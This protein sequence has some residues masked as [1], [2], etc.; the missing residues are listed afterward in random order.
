MKY[1]AEEEWKKFSWKAKI[2]IGFLAFFI[3]IFSSLVADLFTHLF[4]FVWH[5]FGFR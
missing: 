4:W 3:F 5:T 1:D 2:G